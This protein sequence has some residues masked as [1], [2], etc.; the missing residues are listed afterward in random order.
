MAF[1]DRA[2]MTGIAFAEEAG[3]ELFGRGLAAGAGKLLRPFRSKLIKQAPE[4]AELAQKYG[5]HL[6]PGQLTD[7]WTADTLETIADASFFGGRR[8]KKL[9]LRGQPEAIGRYAEDLADAFTKR[10]RKVLDPDSIGRLVD[11]VLSG[12]ARQ[13]RTQATALYT[14]LDKLSGGVTVDITPL[15]AFATKRLGVTRELAG[16]GETE[17]GDKLLKRVLRVGL[18]PETTEVPFK[19]ARELRTRLMR[20]EDIGLAKHLTK[21]LDESME[22]AAKTKGGD[23]YKGWRTVNKFY[24]K[25]MERY[26]NK[27]IEGLV[28]VV[29]DRGEPEKV[30]PYIFKNKGVSRI[31]AV[32]AAVGADSKAWRTLKAKY[33]EDLLDVKPGR[34]IG[35]DIPDKFHRMG[36][37]T[38]KEIFHPDELE[39]IR[40]LGGFATLIGGKASKEMATGGSMVVQLV[41]GGA[42]LSVLTGKFRDIATP[43]FVLPEVV[44]QLATH[45]T[46]AK[47]LSEGFD[48]PV[49]M[50]EAAALSARLLNAVRRAEKDI[51]RKKGPEPRF[52]SLSWNIL[53]HSRRKSSLYLKATDKTAS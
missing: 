41:Q 2:K 40:K 13:F 33:V 34:I 48:L 4:L 47:W 7:A 21:L 37:T 44:S 6:T 49:R 29:E 5:T 53:S 31:K 12:R 35:T 3:G 51:R 25:G 46:T 23:L 26:H 19:V 22:K 17:A 27:I 9:K 36:E 11:D 52:A 42:V 16:I 50:P 28:K 24:R 18:E 38:L 39:A 43:I 32:K 10:T 45:K 14:Q 15:Q 8:M 1:K 20:E 30:I